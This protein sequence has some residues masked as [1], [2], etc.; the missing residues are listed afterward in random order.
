MNIHFPCGHWHKR[1][2][3]TTSYLA[4]IAMNSTGVGRTV[5][6]TVPTLSRSYHDLVTNTG[7]Y[8]AN[9]DAGLC[10]DTANG[11]LHI[12]VDY[13]DYTTTPTTYAQKIA[14]LDATTLA[15]VDSL[16]IT[17]AGNG[18]MMA[19]CHDKQNG[20]L[21]CV[22][23]VGAVYT[24]YEVSLSTFTV[25]RSNTCVGPYT[26]SQT[27][28]RMF[29][30]GAYIY[31]FS[32]RPDATA[33]Y[34]AKLYRFSISDFATDTL[35]LDNITNPQI[36]AGLIGETAYDSINQKLYVCVPTTNNNPKYEY[37]LKRIDIGTA[38]VDDTIALPVD[39]NGYGYFTQ[40]MVVDSNGYVHALCTPADPTEGYVNLLSLL[41]YD[42]TLTLVS[43]ID[44]TDSSFAGF[45]I[46]TLG[47]ALAIAGTNLV[48]YLQ[49][50]VGA[51]YGVC[52]VNYNISSGIPSQTK[53]LALGNSNDE[54]GTFVSSATS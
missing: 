31:Y 39:A 7:S 46:G 19:M 38:S 45:T 11:Y 50:V 30:S 8:A 18:Q 27:E 49:G 12:A 15:E 53:Y 36:L 17:S 20:F 35:L 41:T 10:H 5:R 1:P 13:M 26:G 34:T 24:M 9:L 52:Y 6:L 48:A 32:I 28:Y 23:R 3:T 29:I 33:P 42:T 22:A 51:A 2:L 16:T 43:Q 40:R 47:G 25:S 54:A 4:F 21:Y 37:T 44:F 14:K